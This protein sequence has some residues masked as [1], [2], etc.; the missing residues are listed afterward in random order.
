[1]LSNRATTTTKNFIFHLIYRCR[2][3]RR[4]QSKNSFLPAS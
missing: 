2:K 1:L 4:N 3:K